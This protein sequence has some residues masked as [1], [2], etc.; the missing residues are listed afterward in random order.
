MVPFTNPFST[1][2]DV[3]CHAQVSPDDRPDG[4]GMHG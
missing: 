4:Q 1:P 2:D 3:L